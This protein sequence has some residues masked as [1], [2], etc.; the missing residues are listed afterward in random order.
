MD[1][2]ILN[3]IFNWNFGFCS[4]QICKCKENS[5]FST[6]IL[7][8]R[9]SYQIELH[10]LEIAAHFSFECLFAVLM[11]FTWMRKKLALKCISMNYMEMPIKSK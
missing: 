2:Y 6:K 3:S 10:F 8:K 11:N 9:V 5:K 1:I 4:V 7:F